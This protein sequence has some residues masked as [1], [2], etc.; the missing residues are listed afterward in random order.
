M[1]GCLQSLCLLPLPPVPPRCLK[2]GASF[3]RLK[4][5]ASFLRLQVGASFRR[6]KVSAYFLFQLSF[7]SVW[8]G[9]TRY[10]TI[11]A[12][13][14][15]KHYPKKP[16]FPTQGYGILNPAGAILRMMKRANVLKAAA[17]V[18]FKMVG[19]FVK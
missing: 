3:L 9:K 7:H 16:G 19:R 11:N 18:S 1:P 4:I 10:V 2:V 14:T 5:G 13:T 12:L 6:L 17:A 15:S 8:K